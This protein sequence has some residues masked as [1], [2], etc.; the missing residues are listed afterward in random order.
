MATMATPFALLSGDGSAQYVLSFSVIN[1]DDPILVRRSVNS[2]FVRVIVRDLTCVALMA[3]ACMI[4][5]R[6]DSSSGRASKPLL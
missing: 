2:D 5:A 3:D 1:E 4:G 6:N